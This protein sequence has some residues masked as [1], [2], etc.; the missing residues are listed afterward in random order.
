[1]K[2]LTKCKVCNRILGI[3]E[4]EK[5]GMEMVF[6]LNRILFRKFL[7]CSVVHEISSEHCCV[8]Y[9]LE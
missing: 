7:H 9:V 1:M 8:Y 6:S 5:E 2:L 3:S 4:E